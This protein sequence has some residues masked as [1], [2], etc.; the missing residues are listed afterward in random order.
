MHHDFLQENYNGNRMGNTDDAPRF[1][2]AKAYGRCRFITEADLLNNTEAEGNDHVVL[3]VQTALDDFDSEHDWLLLAGSP[4]VS[5]IV[6]WVLGAMDIKNV[7]MLRWSN[8]DHVY[9][10]VLVRL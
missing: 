1:A 3:D 2:P 5:A 4:Y 6:F 8:R 9:Q 10:E 7:R